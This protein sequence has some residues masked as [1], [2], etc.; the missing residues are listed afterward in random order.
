MSPRRPASPYCRS[1][2]TIHSRTNAS[3]IGHES[4]SRDSAIVNLTA[5]FTGPG[6]SDTGQFN[7]GTYLAD[8]GPG[9]TILFRQK[10]QNY[11]CHGDQADCLFYLRR[12][13]VNIFTT[14]RSGKKATIRLVTAG[15]FFGEGALEET[16]APRT[17]SAA[18]ATDSTAVRIER[19]ELVRLMNEQPSFSRLFSLYLLSRVVK[20]QDDLVDQLLN[21]AEKRL[22]RLLLE[23]AEKGEPGQDESPFIPEITQESMANMIGST[24]PRVNGFITH[25]R[26]LGLIEINDGIRVHRGPIREFLRN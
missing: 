21:N 20:Q 7:I 26:Q 16:P 9:R 12:G 4:M 24:R 3:E 10:G 8:T 11:F 15:E 5:R 2:N 14:A 25:F 17:T 1:R 19:A 23:L 13:R 18:A 6:R 22:A